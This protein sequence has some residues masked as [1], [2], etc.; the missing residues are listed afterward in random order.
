MKSRMSWHMV[1]V[2]IRKIKKAREN[3]TLISINHVLQLALISSFNKLVSI[4]R[5]D[6]ER[7]TCTST[8]SLSKYSV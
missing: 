4:C 7:T 8:N 2:M 6:V 5:A 1:K 3:K